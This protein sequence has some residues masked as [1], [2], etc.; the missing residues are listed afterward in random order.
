MLA[1]HRGDIRRYLQQQHPKADAPYGIEPECLETFVKSC[2]GI[3]TPSRVVVLLIPVTE[4]LL[5]TIHCALPYK[6]W[7]HS[8]REPT[9]YY[10]LRTIVQALSTFLPRAYCLLPTA[11]C[12]LPYRLLVLLV[13]IPLLLHYYD[14]YY[15]TNTARAYHL[16]WQATASPCTCSG[17][18]TGAVA[19]AVVVV[20]VV[21]R[22]HV[23]AGG[24]RQAQ[25]VVGISAV[26]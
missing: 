14:Y 6:R 3:C 25:A 11:L 12:A 7:V 17:S 10:S 21:L 9:A 15:K 24:R 4:S 5:L 20:V 19:V 13:L 22:R 26:Q 2:A 16:P 23:L 1:E 8:H 18:A